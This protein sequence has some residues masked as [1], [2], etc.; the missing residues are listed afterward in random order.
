MD[1]AAVKTSEIVLRIVSKHAKRNAGEMTAS[2]SL[3][4]LGIDSLA[5]AEIIFEIEEQFNVEIPEPSNIDERFKEFRTAQDIIEAVDE[6][7]GQKG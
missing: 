7:V 3:Q 6:L 2:T 5:M 4:G 1:N